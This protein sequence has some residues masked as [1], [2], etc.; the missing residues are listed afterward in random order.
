MR[1]CYEKHF[2]IPCVKFKGSEKKNKPLGFGQP[3][4]K[5]GGGFTPLPLMINGLDPHEGVAQFTQ[6]LFGVAIPFVTA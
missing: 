1:A 2:K 5:V 4:K 3:S 6:F